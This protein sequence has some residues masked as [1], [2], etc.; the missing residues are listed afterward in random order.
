VARIRLIVRLITPHR[1]YPTIKKPVRE[2]KARSRAMLCMYYTNHVVLTSSLS[3]TNRHLYVIRR[4][5]SVVASWSRTHG[6]AVS[7]P[8]RF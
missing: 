3:N 2:A 5:K 6:L 1:I 7:N 4:V 8:S